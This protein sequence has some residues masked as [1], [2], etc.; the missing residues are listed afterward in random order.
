MGGTDS[1]EAAGTQAQGLSPRVRGNPR[2]AFSVSSSRRTIP[3]GAG[4]PGTLL[5]TYGVT[6]DY[7]RGCGGTVEL[8]ALALV[9]GG[10][11]PR[12]RGNRIQEPAGNAGRGT[13]PA[14][15]GEPPADSTPTPRCRDYPRGCGGTQNPTRNVTFVPGLSPRVR[16]NPRDAAVDDRQTGTIPAGAGEPERHRKSA[17]GMGDYPRGCGGTASVWGFEESS[18]GL[19][20][21]V[22]GNRNGGFG[23]CGFWGTIPAG[24]GEPLVVDQAQA[25]EGDY[26]RGC[27]GTSRTHSKTSG[28]RGLSPRVRGNRALG[29]ARIV[30][31]G[32]I[33]AGAGEPSDRG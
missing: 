10:L 24:A 2:W 28:A 19:S 32:T 9:I 30:E 15:A 7:P 23:C 31:I 8:H 11:S 5:A 18:K 20:P 21:R 14:G 6:W 25:L 16:G 17:A 26:P 22:R 13:I 27:G 33:P 4:E 29:G 12:V 1:G 3:A